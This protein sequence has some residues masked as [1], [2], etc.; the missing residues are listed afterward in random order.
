MSEQEPKQD[1]TDQDETPQAP[2]MWDLIADA[3][4]APPISEEDAQTVIDLQTA[5]T[6]GWERAQQA[7]TP[8]GDWLR[9]EM[10]RHLP[11]RDP[12]EVA[13]MS[14]EIVDTLH[15]QEEAKA[16]LREAVARGRSKEAWFADRMQ[17]FASAQ[18]AQGTAAAHLARLD[19]AVADANQAMAGTFLTQAGAVNQNPHLDGFMAERY[20]VE[21][22]NLNA[23]ANGSQYR[24]EVLGGAGK[25]GYGKNSV[26][27]VIKDAN[28]KIV[29]RYQVKYGKDGQATRQLFE[30]GDYRGQ[31]KLVP[32]DQKGEVSGAT[33]TLQA[34]DGTRS[35]PLTRPNAKKL[36]ED[37]QSGRWND[38]DWKEYRYR[39]LSIGLGKQ[40]GKAALIGAAIGAGREVVGKLW[41]GEEIEGKAVAK[42]ALKDG[43]DFGA[44]AAVA[45]ALKVAA[46]KGAFR[47]AFKGV[48]SGT[49]ANVAFVAVENAKILYKMGRGELTVEEG[50]DQMEQTTVAALAGLA[51]GAKGAAIGAAVGMAFGPPGAIIGGFVG[52]AVGYMAGSAAGTAVVKAGQAVRK[53]V[54]EK[55]RGLAQR[56]NRKVKEAVRA[57]LFA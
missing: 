56:A 50:V 48:A 34:P 41:R 33:D 54:G 28:G 44:K 39:D 3:T 10:A 9:D 18:T 4:V 26:D 32:A 49:W 40:V 57:W 46:E 2:E 8:V 6:A 1:R 17:E 13:A 20:H 35:N 30:N 45:G 12:G 37:A 11:E 27:I 29:R 21:T 14:A 53:W 38:L 36:Q 7:G 16:S 51:V 47:G 5:F 31:R 23:K 22:F 42:A 43:A 15:R 52:S 25:G 24:A 19:E 55:I